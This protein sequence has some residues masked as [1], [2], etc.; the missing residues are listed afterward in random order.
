MDIQSINERRLREQ[1]D[2]LPPPLL[3]AYKRER[4]RRI[5][6]LE[7]ARAQ[8]RAV[9]LVPG[10]K[11]R[12]QPADW[13]VATPLIMVSFANQALAAGALLDPPCTDFEG[14]LHR[15]V[16]VRLLA[17]PLAHLGGPTRI[18]LLRSVRTFAERILRIKT[19]GLDKAILRIRASELAR[20]Y[21]GSLRD[22][23][24]YRA[25]ALAL[26]PHMHPDEPHD[27]ITAIDA[28]NKAIACL[29]VSIDPRLGEISGL[30]R[31]S[32]LVDGNDVTIVILAGTSKERKSQSRALDPECAKPVIEYAC[33]TRP[34]LIE[35]RGKGTP[36]SSAF[37]LTNVGTRLH[38][39]GVDQAL[40]RVLAN[41]MGSPVSSRIIRKA[42]A[43]RE[44]I[45]EAE[46]GAALGHVLGSLLGIDVYSVRDI[47]KARRQLV[48]MWDEA[49][50][51]GM[52]HSSL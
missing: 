40:S 14:L 26:E 27:L 52:A 43:S 51:F 37:W 13:A 2:R 5:V 31:Q 19:E 23:A 47:S 38:P 17:G 45:A 18:L 28:R 48:S 25:A 49:D 33:R 3:E 8:A 10:L 44:D 9:P 4:G 41:A 29:A 42:M 39:D 21:T 6:T 15:P 50:K 30:S 34:Y 35:R 20:D 46:I 7:E 22:Y 24:E 32:V 1:L 36:A 16:M 11:R 12:M